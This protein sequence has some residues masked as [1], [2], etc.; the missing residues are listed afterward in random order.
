MCKEGILVSGVVSRG[1]CRAYWDRLYPQG[2]MFKGVASR[3]LCPTVSSTFTNGSRASRYGVRSPAMPTNMFCFVPLYHRPLYHR[4]LY[5]RPLYHRPL[6]HRP[7]YHRPLYHR[8]GKYN[9]NKQ[10][11]VSVTVKIFAGITRGPITYQR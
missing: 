6:Y 8:P 10:A 9:G 5:H 11:P 4:P 3:G 1:F 2:L 7:L